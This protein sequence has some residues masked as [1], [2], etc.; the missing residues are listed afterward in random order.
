MCPAPEAYSNS[1]TSSFST[2]SSISTSPSS[3][4]ATS[5]SGCSV[6]PACPSPLLPFSN[7]ASSRICLKSALSIAKAFGAL[8]F[9]ITH[10]TA[11]P[12][13]RMMPSFACCAMQSAYALLMMYHKTSVMLSGDVQRDSNIQ[14]LLSQCE[15]GLHSILAALDNYS[16]SFEAMHGMRG[17][18]MTTVRSCH[19][20]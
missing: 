3:S 6:F 10:G 14:K 9:P 1:E 5:V 11:D 8:P 12:I 19:G 15:Q 2:H 17:E 18:H 16:I 13:P 20:S 7:N 4:T